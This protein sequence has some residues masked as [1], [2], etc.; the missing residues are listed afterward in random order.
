V[1][2]AGQDEEIDMPGDGAPVMVNGKMRQG[3]GSSSAL[4]GAPAAQRARRAL[5]LQRR[6]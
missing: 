3:Y 5:A 4:N 6:C 2:R 1:T